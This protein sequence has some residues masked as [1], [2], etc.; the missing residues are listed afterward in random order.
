[1]STDIPHHLALAGHLYKAFH[2]FYLSQIF[3]VAC[4]LA[5]LKSVVYFHASYTHS[6]WNDF[7]FSPLTIPNLFY[8]KIEFIIQDPA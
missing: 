6:V 5:I 3:W 7:L 8:P 2:N 1:M 4:S